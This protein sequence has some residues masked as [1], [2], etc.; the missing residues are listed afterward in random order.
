MQRETITIAAVS[1]LVATIAEALV[2]A[3][4]TV[5]TAPTKTWQQQQKEHLFTKTCNNQSSSNTKAEHT[6][7][8]K[9][10]T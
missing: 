1:S 3:V 10:P 8:N 6:T 2:V 7:L 4:A 9:T 5:M